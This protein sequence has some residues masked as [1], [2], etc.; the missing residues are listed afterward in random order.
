[1]GRRNSQRAYCT[2]DMMYTRW[3]LEFTGWPGKV[4][5]GERWFTV[6][7]IQEKLHTLDEVVNCD[8]VQQG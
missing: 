5:P 6:M 2:E 8:G 1:M 3:L 7:P 4:E